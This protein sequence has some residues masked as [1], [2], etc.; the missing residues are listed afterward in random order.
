M[1]AAL[2]PSLVL[3]VAVVEHLLPVGLVIMPARLLVLV[4]TE[5]RLLSQVHQ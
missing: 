5:Q 1:V 4:V 2:L 3:V